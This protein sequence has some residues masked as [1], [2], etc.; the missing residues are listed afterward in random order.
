M[1]A[2]NSVV[3]AVWPPL[4]SRLD[5]IR[6]IHVF[7]TVDGKPIPQKTNQPGIIFGGKIAIEM[8]V[9]QAAR[10]AVTHPPIHTIQ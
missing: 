8:V 4:V 10:S 7:P 3:A 5:G 1:P 2:G 9:I 6:T